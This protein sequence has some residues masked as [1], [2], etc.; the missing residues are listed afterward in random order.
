MGIKVFLDD[1]RTPEQAGVTIDWVRTYTPEATIALLE[2][3]GLVDEV[4]LDND[5]ALP[6]Y[7]PGKPR[8][9]YVVF[10]W[11]ENRVATDDSYFPPVIRVHSA[12]TTEANKMRRGFAGIERLLQRR[13]T[14]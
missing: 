7:A 5:L 6:D 9:G 1:N 3:P 10:L 13:G 12:N 11:I 8:E 4:S 2:V 14:A